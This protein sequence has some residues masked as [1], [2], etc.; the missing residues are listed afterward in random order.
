MRK[1]LSFL[2]VKR[3]LCSYFAM[4][5]SRQNMASD[6]GQWQ[7]MSCNEFGMNR[8][9]ELKEKQ[10]KVL[11]PIIRYLSQDSKRPPLKIKSEILGV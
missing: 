7:V 4:L 10:K 3:L 2:A 8:L 11:S 1:K 5:S 6:T 9:A